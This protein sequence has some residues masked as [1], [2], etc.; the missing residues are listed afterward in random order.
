MSLY[1]ENKA[2]LYIGVGEYAYASLDLFSFPDRAWGR[3]VL[4]AIRVAM[5]QFSCGRGFSRNCPLL[6]TAYEDFL[7]VIRTLHLEIVAETYLDGV[8]TIYLRHTVDPD[9]EAIVY[10]KSEYIE[11]GLTPE[12]FLD[13]F[14]IPE[15]P[16]PAGFAGALLYLVSQPCPTPCLENT[17]FV[18]N[19][20]VDECLLRKAL[21]E[22]MRIFDIVGA[23]TRLS[24]QAPVGFCPDCGMIPYETCSEL[25]RDFSYRVDLGKADDEIGGILAAWLFVRGDPAPR[26]LW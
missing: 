9:L 19:Q 8:D 3:D 22:G 2:K 15:V 14:I 25:L 10:L 20:V 23:A 6:D 7:Y 17:I 4:A 26:K 18:L 11:T 24:P 5:M 12:D 1:I 13:T 21:G 16:I